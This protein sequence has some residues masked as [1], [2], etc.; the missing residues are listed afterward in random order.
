MEASTVSPDAAIE[1]GKSKQESNEPAAPPDQTGTGL[2][3]DKVAEFDG[4]PLTQLKLSDLKDKPWR[5]PGS[6]VKDYFNYGFDE[7]SWSYYCSKQDKL[8]GE[9]D[10]KKLMA[11]ISKSSAGMMPPMM[12]M[13]GM[14][15]PMMGMPPMPNN[16]F[17]QQQ[18]SSLPKMPTKPAAQLRS[19]SNTPVSQPLP[20]PSRRDEADRDFE[21]RR[22]SQMNYRD[23]ANSG[24]PAPRGA[25]RKRR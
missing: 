25:V 12:G 2:E 20:P 22:D 5:L 16:F 14:M 23:R 6:D 13:P 24:R 9:F 8:R 3:V 21:L 17:Q 18:N 10:A 7:F 11:E 1:V 19:S 15:P 4:K